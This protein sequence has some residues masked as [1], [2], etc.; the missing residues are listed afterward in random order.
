MI[1]KDGLIQD[2][3]TIMNSLKMSMKV[4]VGEGNA[5]Y[6]FKKQQIRIFFLIQ[7]RSGQDSI[8]CG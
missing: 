8:L 7:S 6:Y 1:K 2:N 3:F 5:R 4:T